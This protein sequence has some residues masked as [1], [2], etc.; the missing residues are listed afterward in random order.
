MH[1]PV[2]THPD[3]VNLMSSPEIERISLNFKSNVHSVTNEIGN[4][5]QTI[6]TL[7]VI[8]ISARKQQSYANCKQFFNLFSVELQNLKI[9]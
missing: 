6:Q 4:H 8:Y 1:A 5:I 7:I 3:S 9:S 2:E